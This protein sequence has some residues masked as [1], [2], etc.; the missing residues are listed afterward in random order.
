V[1]NDPTG[2][3]RLF[4]QIQVARRNAWLA[5]RVLFNYLETLGYNE[6][7]LVGLPKCL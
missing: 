2:V 3:I 1:T 4:S 5:H 7:L 6:G